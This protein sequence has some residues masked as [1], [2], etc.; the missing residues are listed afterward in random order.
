MQGEGE[1]RTGP[2]RVRGARSRL[3]GL[4]M[5]EAPEP[6]SNNVDTTAS[7]EEPADSVPSGIVASDSRCKRRHGLYERPSRQ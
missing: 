2:G 6:D 7:N 1:Q 4:K 5:R 3:D